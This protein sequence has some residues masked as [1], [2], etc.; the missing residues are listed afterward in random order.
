M[1]QPTPIF[2]TPG[3]YITQGYNSNP[4]GR[5]NPYGGRHGGLDIV[6]LNADGSSAWLAPMFPLFGGVTLDVQNTSVERGKG[7]KTRND[8]YGEMIPYLESKGVLPK[9]L[10]G[11]IYLDCLYWH[12]HEVT[13]LDGEV[14]INTEIAKCG[15]TGWVFSGGVQ[16]PDYQK[17][18]PPYPGLHLHFETVLVSELYGILNLDKDYKGRIDPNI[19]INYKY[20]SNVKLVNNKGEWGPFL[21]TTSGEALI[22]KMLNYGVE[23]PKLSNGDVDWS[24]VKADITI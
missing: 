6:P 1:R 16:V 11:K 10:N 7:I 13:D 20:M 3:F 19:I 12:C 4:G 9:N 17:G 22:D 23:I 8:I 14:D 2:K 5:Y 21:P 18:K 24:K 15:N